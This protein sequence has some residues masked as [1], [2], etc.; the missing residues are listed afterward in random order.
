VR[1]APPFRMTARVDVLGARCRR[2]VGRIRVAEERRRRARHTPGVPDPRGGVRGTRPS[3]PPSQC[4]DWAGVR[5]ET[6][7]AAREGRVPAPPDRACTGPRGRLLSQRAR[8]WAARSALCGRFA[9]RSRHATRRL[10]E[11]GLATLLSAAASSDGRDSRRGPRAR[12]AL[13]AGRRLCAVVYAANGCR[14]RLS[15]GSRRGGVDRS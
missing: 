1:E 14:S 4:C 3:R 13:A 8:G 6:A 10:Y 7:A 11:W 5:A 9:T 15:C 2:W 12:R